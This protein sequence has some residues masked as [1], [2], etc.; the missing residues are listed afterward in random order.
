VEC[1]PIICL[2]DD[3]Q[4]FEEFV[5]LLIWRSFDCGDVPLELGEEVIDKCSQQL[6]F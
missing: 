6:L 3:N 5:E 2:G 1:L 4:L